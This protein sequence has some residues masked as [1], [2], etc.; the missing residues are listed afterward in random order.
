M[1]TDL[2]KDMLMSLGSGLVLDLGGFFEIV[3]PLSISLI[4]YYQPQTGNGGIQLEFE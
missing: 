2:S 4:Y 3:F 1:N